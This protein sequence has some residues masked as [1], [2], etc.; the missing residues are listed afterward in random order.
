MLTQEKV[1]YIDH[2]V[3][4]SEEQKEKFCSAFDNNEGVIIIFKH[5]DLMSG[6]D[7][8]SFTEQQFKRIV[9]AFDKGRGL[10]I[11]MSEDQVQKH[12]IVDEDD[13]FLSPF[14]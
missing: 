4:I 3:N 1:R 5:E 6:H 9:N 7:L 2:R 10:T 11:K 12:E 14:V 13:Y 8:I